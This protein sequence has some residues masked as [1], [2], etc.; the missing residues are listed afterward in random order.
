LAARRAQ[1]PVSPHLAIYKWQIGSVMSSLMRITGV[2]YAGSFYIF[3]VAYLASPY[4]G[5]DLSSTAIA[6]SI[7]SLP[8]VAQAALK[9]VVAWPLALHCINGVRHLTWDTARGFNRRFIH[10]TGWMV[11]G[12]TTMVVGYMTIV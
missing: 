10:R 6:A 11:V 5:W 7:A 8:V 1:R 4:V 3:S 2:T 9:F 12:A